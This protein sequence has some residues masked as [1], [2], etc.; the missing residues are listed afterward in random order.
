MRV[1]VSNIAWAPEDDARAADVL[2][3]L[4]VEAVEVAPTTRWADPA[5]V[6]PDE[7]RAYRASWA[8]RGLEVSSLQALLYGRDD[9]K[10]FADEGVRTALHA[11][12][13]GVARLAAE[14][15]AGPLVFGSPK[16]RLKG[17]LSPA[18]AR[19]RAV[20]FF[21]DVA[22]AIQ[23]L[24]TVLVLEANPS[25]YGAD[26]VTHTHDMVDLVEAVDHPAFGAHL[27]LGGMQIAGEPV[28]EWVAR[29]AHVL[30]HVHVSEPYLA[31]VGAS[32]LD[33]HAVA[34]ALRHVGYEGW[35]S[36]EMRRDAERDPVDS[37]ADAA[38]RVVAAYGEPR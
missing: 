8:E 33:H 37:V 26:F 6:P 11:H 10:L 38:R 29:S 32:R 14:L 12:L 22:E 18:E 5:R 31:P 19:E 17:T 30:R 16:N 13:V 7:A 35:I 28:T 23:P 36:I 2:T 24:G 3:S 15:G 4:G 21:R 27:D 9:L 25:E 34:D 20:V 1:S